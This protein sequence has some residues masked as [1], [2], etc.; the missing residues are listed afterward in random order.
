MGSLFCNRKVGRDLFLLIMAK[1]DPEDLLSCRL[2]SRAWCV[3]ASSNFLWE[4]LV[5]MDTVPDCYR[6]RLFRHYVMSN[7]VG[8]QTFDI[9]VTQYLL[10]ESGRKVF[11]DMVH[12][13]HGFLGEPPIDI[14]NKS[15]GSLM[16]AWPNAKRTFT[17]KPWHTTLVSDN[18]V[19]YALKD[20]VMP[21]L[22]H[23]SCKIKEK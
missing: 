14:V 19:L 4:P 2:V 7:F 15:D 13:G 5:N 23:Q 16:V 6:D 22:L 12:L 11:F 21:Y 1:L 17:L 9:D 3:L 18:N 10:S 8:I 20:F